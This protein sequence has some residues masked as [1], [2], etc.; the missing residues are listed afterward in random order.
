MTVFKVVSQ[1]K[2]DQEPDPQ[3]FLFSLLVVPIDGDVVTG[4]E[5]YGYET[6]H[7]FVV[8]V[9]SVKNQ[10]E[11]QVLECETRPHRCTIIFLMA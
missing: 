2:I 6:H 9:R 8:K 4:F 5:F 1:Y 3:K 10:N 7:P 11:K